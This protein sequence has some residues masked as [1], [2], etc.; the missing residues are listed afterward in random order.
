M[1]G[2]IFDFQVAAVEH[3]HG[4][5]GSLPRISQRSRKPLSVSSPIS[6]EA[7]CCGARRGTAF[8]PQA[9]L[10]DE[11]PDGRHS[12]DREAFQPRAVLVRRLVPSTLVDNVLVS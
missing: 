4:I 5:D 9:A 3:N 11:C 2:K 12:E 10:R 8:C 6:D 1:Q 7:D